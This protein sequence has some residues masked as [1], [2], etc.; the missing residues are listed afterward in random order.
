MGDTG[1]EGLVH[2]AET[3]NRDAA[4]CRRAHCG[5]SAEAKR[6]TLSIRG[7]RAHAGVERGALIGLDA[8]LHGATASLNLECRVQ[9][10]ARVTIA[11]PDFALLPG[12]YVQVR[13]HIRDE[14]DA[15]MAPQAALG[16]NQMGKFVYVVGAGDKAELRLLTLGA[17]DGE[18]VSVTKGLS[19]GER[20]IVGNLQKIGPGSPVKPLPQ[21]QKPTR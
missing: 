3:L 21:E 14:P 17:M 12:Q 1:Q 11:N 19:E 2:G 13:L 16:S 8:R 7:Q 20:V 4:E 9:E 5:W 6:D 18:L 15:V 10:I